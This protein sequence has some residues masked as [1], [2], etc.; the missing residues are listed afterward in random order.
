MVVL[1]FERWPFVLANHHLA[2]EN[3]ILD[4]RLRQRLRQ[5]YPRLRKLVRVPDNE[6]KHN[7]QLKEGQ[8]DSLILKGR[9]FPEWAYCPISREFQHLRAWQTAWL[10]AGPTPPPKNNPRTE[11]NFNPPMSTVRRRGT[12]P[13]NGNPLPKR[14]QALEQIRFVLAGPNGELADVPWDR[15]VFA[16]RPD[17]VP[18]ALGNGQTMQAT[19]LDFHRALPPGLTLHYT[20]QERAGDL[21]GILLT[22]RTAAGE[23]A[24]DPAGNEYRKSLAGLYSLRVSRAD[25]V[26]HGLLFG[27]NGHQGQPRPGDEFILFRPVIRS[28]NSAYYANSLDSLFIPTALAQCTTDVVDELQRLHGQFAALFPAELLPGALLKMLP[29]VSQQYVDETYIQQLIGADF[30]F[31]E[32]VNNAGE[33]LH[34]Q[35]EF[36]YLVS[37][38]RIIYQDTYSRR[39]EMK[40]ERA[41]TVP[42]PGLKSVTRIDKLKVITVQPSFTRLA[43]IP[44]DDVLRPDAYSEEQPDVPADVEQGNQPRKQFVTEAGP[45]SEFLPAYESFG[46]GIFLQFDPIKLRE[47]EEENPGVNTQM[48]YLLHNHAQSWQRRNEEAPTAAQV[49]LHT[50]SHL[51]MRELEFRCGYQLTS[52][53]ER[54]YAGPAMNGL[55]IY[56]VAGSAGSYGGL[57]SLCDDQQLWELILSALHRATDCASDPICWDSKAEGQGVG[58]LN[59]AACASCTLLPETSCEE[60][61][62]LLDRRLVVDPD[63]GYFKEV[64]AAV[65]APHTAAISEA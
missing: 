30:R 48:Q 34:R 51:L 64:V 39:V 28:S 22:A 49:L 40:F 23:T 10:L 4:A 21:G 16:Q 15:W 42:L 13:P 53:K 41:D 59:L 14:N 50:F 54:L 26:S 27:Q 57:V 6:I 17:R 3:E 47:W 36:D 2:R 31:T 7:F 9:Y 46:E 56:T 35:A 18:V 33:R 25:L 38:P 32:E 45:D 19:A 37:N 43:P 58:G 55:L 65:S 29:P 8:D 61:N 20:V 44:A 12:P 52:L 62:S 60:F 11:D 24:Q 5:L 1:P 63:F